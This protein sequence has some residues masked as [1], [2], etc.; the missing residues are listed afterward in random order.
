MTTTPYIAVL[1]LNFVMIPLWLIPIFGFVI[2][3]G[4]SFLF[5]PVVLD[6]G[7]VLDQV[8]CSR[9]VV[10]L[11]MLGGCMWQAIIWKNRSSDVPEIVG[12]FFNAGAITGTGCAFLLA[13]GLIRGW[14]WTKPPTVRSNQSRV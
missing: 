13:L 6:R 8:V 7:K 5:I 2:F 1:L 4:M 12:Y 11:W 9:F 14:Y 3:L 10:A